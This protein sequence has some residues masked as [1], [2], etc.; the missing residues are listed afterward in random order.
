M[1]GRT[2]VI[3]CK[4]AYNREMQGTK[5]FINVVKVPAMSLILRE[6][7]STNSIRAHDDERNLCSQFME[8]TETCLNLLTVTR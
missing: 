6:Q 1:K 5:W 8:E 7:L 2:A 3:F 4:A